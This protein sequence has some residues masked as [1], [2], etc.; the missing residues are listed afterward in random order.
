MPL[1]QTIPD[2]HQRTRQADR[3]TQNQ[4]QSLNQAAASC[5]HMA[6]D[7]ID[8]SIQQWH[9]RYKIQHTGSDGHLG[10]SIKRKSRRS[11]QR[12]DK[13]RNHKMM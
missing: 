7:N 3:N 8:N 5:Q 10:S 2:H 6:F 13:C 4:Q 1:Q 9:T 11:H 12:S